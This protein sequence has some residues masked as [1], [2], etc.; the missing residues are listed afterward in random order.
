MDQ[1]ASAAAEEGIA[2]GTAEDGCTAR[3]ADEEQVAAGTLDKVVD[4][5][6]RIDRFGARA[7]LDRV[8]ADGLDRIVLLPSKMLLLP[9]PALTSQ[10]PEPPSCNVL[11]PPPAATVPEPPDVAKTRFVW[12][13]ERIACPA[14]SEPK[15]RPGGTGVVDGVD[16]IAVAQGDEVAGGLNED[17]GLARQQCRCGLRPLGGHVGGRVAATPALIGG[18]LRRQRIVGRGIVIER[19]ALR[20]RPDYRYS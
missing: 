20:V 6:L 13:S 8:V 1:A 11:F 12:A 14:A 18:D 3:T 19:Y 15:R 7:A 10:L 4:C 9:A 17:A 16:R 5:A 2:A